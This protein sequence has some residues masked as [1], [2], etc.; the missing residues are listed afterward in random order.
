MANRKYVLP[1]IVLAQFMCTSLWFA[2]NAVVAQVTVEY[3]LAGGGIGAITSAVQL[4]FIAGTL[5]YA[6]LTIPDRFHPSK[7]FFVSAVLGAMAN[8]L[9]TLDSLTYASVLSLRF[10][11]GFFLAGIYPVGMKIASDYFEKG[12]GK[13]LGFLV[14]ALVLGT[15]LPYGIAGMEAVPDWRSVLYVT[16][17][18]ALAGGLLIILFVPRGPFHTPGSRVR[19]DALGSIFQNEGYRKAAFGYFGHMWELYAFW[20]FVPVMLSYYSEANGYSQNLPLLAFAI[21]GIGSVACVASGILSLRFGE[22]R[23]ASWALLISGVCCLVSPLFFQA[24][25]EWFV[26]FL[27]IWGVAVIADSP[28]LSSLVAKNAPA[29]LKG[30]AITLATCIGFA[31]TII[32]IQLLSYATMFQPAIS[33]LLLA[34]GPILGLLALRKA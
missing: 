5:T 7:V 29:A 6:L 25:A 21:L 34:P 30:T 28:L 31:I 20:A 33:Y 8:S 11:T 26:A 10:L 27:L 3:Q 4:G 15:A 16:S 1:I 17:A 23:V 2:G 14:G 13:A 24:K 19:L 32:S 9:I 18:L 12:L 22:N